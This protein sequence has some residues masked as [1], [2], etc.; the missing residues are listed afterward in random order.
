MSI[1]RLSFFFIGLW[2][3][4]HDLFL[5]TAPGSWARPRQQ[6]LPA[7]GEGK[8]CLFFR[9]YL[10]KISVPCSI[11]HDGG[12]ARRVHYPAGALSNLLT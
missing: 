2:G 6:K 10:N 4:E 11:L 5:K 3:P 12:S 9:F 7:K 1:L 8:V